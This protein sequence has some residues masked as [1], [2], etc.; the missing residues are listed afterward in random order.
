MWRGNVSSRICLSVCLSCS[1]SIFE[2]I[3]LEINRASALV[4]AISHKAI[5]LC[6][7]AREGKENKKKD[8][9]TSFLICKHT[10]SGYL[11]QGRVSRS[12]GQGQGHTSVTKYTHVCGAF[13]LQPLLARD[14]FVRTNRRA[15]AMMFVCLS[16]CPSGSDVHCDHTVH[17]SA[18]FSPVPS[19]REV[20]HGCAN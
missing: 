19:G 17:F 15:V 1:G 5:S 3:G 18:D 14:A 10:S 16:V 7:S 8:L 4:E 11:G 2:S 6:F 13:R 20:G 12:R 9:G